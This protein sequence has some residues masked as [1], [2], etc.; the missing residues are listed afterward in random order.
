MELGNVLQ[1]R[2]RSK[3]RD[4]NEF[5]TV[6]QLVKRY[7]ETGKEQDLIAVIKALEGIVNTYTLMLSPG[8]NNQQIFVTP[9]MKKFLGMFLTPEE[10]GTPAAQI[11]NQALARVR[12]IMRNYEYED[13]YSFILSVLIQVIKGMKIVG[14]CDCI[15]YIQ[16]IVRYKLHDLVI[17][18]AKD[19]SASVESTGFHHTNGSDITEETMDEALDRMSFSSE[20]LKYEDRL[21]SSFYDEF[22]ISI[23][24]RKDD[25]FKCL[26]NYEKYLIYLKDYLDLTNKQILN[27][28]K[29]ETDA[30]LNERFEDIKFKLELIAQEGD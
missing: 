16:L 23:L 1:N 28:L 13:V 9:Y 14:D 8:D 27:I 22:D 26:G 24:N 12:W 4:F 7:K 6:T 19:A 10:R 17:K 2:K 30:E 15:Y 5:S 18:S 20:N 25:I 11:Y 29:F 21:I 3:R